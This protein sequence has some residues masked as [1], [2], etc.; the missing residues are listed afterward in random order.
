MRPQLGWWHI[1]TE[2]ENWC[3]KEKGTNITIVSSLM[4]NV[5]KTDKIRKFRESSLGIRV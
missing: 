5:E 4:T 1:K 3:L 2:D